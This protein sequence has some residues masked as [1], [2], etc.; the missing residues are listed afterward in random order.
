MPPSGQREKYLKKFSDNPFTAPGVRALIREM[1]VPACPE[2]QVEAIAFDLKNHV[3]E[4]ALEGLCAACLP[5]AGGVRVLSGSHP[6]TKGDMVLVLPRDLLRPG[7]LD[8]FRPGEGV[9]AVMGRLREKYG[10]LPE[11]TAAVIQRQ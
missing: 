4:P 3:C 6:F 11:I 2:I 5:A 8:A 7:E 1:L 9:S 10:N